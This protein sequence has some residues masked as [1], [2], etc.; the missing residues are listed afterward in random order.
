MIRASEHSI[1][2]YSVIHKFSKTCL[3][4]VSTVRSTERFARTSE[5]VCD[6]LRESEGGG[7]V[8]GPFRYPNPLALWIADSVQF[9]FSPDRSFDKFRS[10]LFDRF[11]GRLSAFLCRFCCLK[12]PESS[13]GGLL[14][15]SAPEPEDELLSSDDILSPADISADLG[16]KI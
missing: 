14:R 3:P 16:D 11:L 15:C 5:I 2:H 1:V 8:L 4:I 12:E 9:C 7:G 6:G 13:L 10:A